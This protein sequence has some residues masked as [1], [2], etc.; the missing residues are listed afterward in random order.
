MAARAEACSDL[1][2]DDPNGRRKRKPNPN[3]MSSDR[4]ETLSPHKKVSHQFTPGS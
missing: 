3:Y 2:S 1:N 4:D